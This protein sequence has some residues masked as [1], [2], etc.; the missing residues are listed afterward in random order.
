MMGDNAADAGLDAA[1]AEE[2]RGFAEMDLEERS[3]LQDLDRS[4]V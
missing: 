2:I 4:T 3:G 1:P